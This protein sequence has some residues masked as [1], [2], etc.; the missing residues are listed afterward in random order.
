MKHNKVLVF[1]LGILL[2]LAGCSTDRTSVVARAA[3]FKRVDFASLRTWKYDDHIAALKSFRKSC[4]VI[5][6]KKSNIKIGKYTD[7]GGQTKDWQYV[8]RQAQLYTKASHTAREFFEKFFYP[9]EV[10]DLQS[11]VQGYFTGYHE[12]ELRGSLKKSAKYKYPVYKAPSNINIDR[13]Y[14]KFS[15]ESIENGTLDKSNLEIAWVD[16]KK[17]L[18]DMHVQGSGVIILDDHSII[19]LNYHSENG[20][21]QKTKR[22]FA[23]TKDQSY[24]FFNE[25]KANNP[26]GAQ[27]VEL[28]KERSIAIDHKIFPYGTPFWIETKIAYRYSNKLSEYNRLMIA[29][30]TGGQIRGSVRAD[31]FFGRGKEAAYM[32][33][34]MK[35]RG[36]YYA[37]FPK[38]VNIP[39]TYEY[40]KLF[41]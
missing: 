20:F 30:D 5:L 28:E 10:S 18:I 14:S 17:K 22:L 37:L 2:L 15:R 11:S 21:S 12:I 32:A 4:A 34:R 31:L 33:K 24:V 40:K 9:Y 39:K 36:R 3:K 1:V 16:N 13:R 19:R 27:G 29:Q 6:S 38:S 41:N 8:C 7:I 26:I 25:R 35:N 23:K